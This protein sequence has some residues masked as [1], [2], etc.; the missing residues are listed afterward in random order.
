MNKHLFKQ[1]L[2]GANLS[3]SLSKL[4]TVILYIG[5]ILA[6]LVFLFLLVYGINLAS[7]LNSAGSFVTMLFTALLTSAAIFFGSY[8]SSAFFKALASITLHTY[9][10]AVNSENM[11]ETI[12]HK[13]S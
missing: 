1:E 4:S 2:N 8:V 3:A 7:I 6:G 10:S 12:L 11:T 5:G 13:K 9:I